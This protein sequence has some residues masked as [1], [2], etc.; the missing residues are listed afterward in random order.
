MWPRVS[1]PSQPGCPCGAKVLAELD[2]DPAHAQLVTGDAA[3]LI[4]PSSLAGRRARL[5]AFS[6]AFLL[7]PD[8]SSGSRRSNSSEFQNW[9]HFSVMSYCLG[10]V[11]SE[12]ARIF[13]SVLD[14]FGHFNLPLPG[15][16]RNVVSVLPPCV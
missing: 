6:S 12:L 5:C 10:L 3:Q 16:P 7:P 1:G 13:Q 15:L 11:R 14:D 9:C 2:L 4:E 8:I